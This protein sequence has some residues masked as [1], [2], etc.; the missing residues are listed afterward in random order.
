MQ[1]DISSLKAKVDKIDVDKL[2]A[3][4]V[5]LMKLSNVVNNVVKKLCKIN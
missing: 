4:L 1:K 2:K 3:V 5:D